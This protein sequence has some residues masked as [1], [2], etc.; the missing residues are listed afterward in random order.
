LT[1]HYLVAQAGWFTVHKYLDKSGRFVNFA[2]H[3]KYK[4]R[5]TKI[6]VEAEAFARIRRELDRWGF[7]AATLYADLPGLCQHVERQ[8]S[9]LSDEPA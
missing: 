5:L 8:H 3:N 7:N 9:L 1:G 6:V 2:T 4:D